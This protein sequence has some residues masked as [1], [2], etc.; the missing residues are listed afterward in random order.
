MNGG[1]MERIGRVEVK[2]FTVTVNAYVVQFLTTAHWQLFI[3]PNV[4]H[5]AR[6]WYSTYREEYLSGI[7]L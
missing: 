7:G 3:D 4:I 5:L 6:P 2:I 1:I